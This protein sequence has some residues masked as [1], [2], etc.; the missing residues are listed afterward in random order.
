MANNLDAILFD[1][2]NN[3]IE[4][5]SLEKPKTYQELLSI[6]KNKLKKLPN[7]FNII[8]QTLNG[9]EINI[10]SDQEFKLI[11]DIIFIREIKKSDLDKSIFSLNYNNLSESKQEILDEKFNCSICFKNI[12]NENP[13][14]CYK[15]Q[16]IFH[17]E[18]LDDWDKKNKGQNKNLSCP[19][20]RNELPLEKWEHKL[21]FEDDRKKE[22]YKMDKFSQYDLIININK[23]QEKKINELIL[24]NEKYKKNLEEPFNYIKDILIKVD[25]II[26]IKNPNNIQN[27]NNKTIDLIKNISIKNNNFPFKDI[28]QIIFKKL[29]IIKKNINN[30]NNDFKYNNNDLNEIK[31]L[32]E[33]LK[34]L[35][36]KNDLMNIYEFKNEFNLIYFTKFEGYFNIF[37]KSFILNNK[38]K[39]EI[40]I[41]D[42]KKSTMYKY[43]LNKGDNKIKILIK[44]KLTNLE[45]MFSECTTLK[46]IG[47]LKFLDTKEI[48]SFTRM[49][50][51]CTSLTD[52]TALMNWN[53]SNC[54]DFSYMFSECTSLSE[55]DSLQLWNV[56]NG[57]N[58]S[59]MFNSCIAL[60]NIKPLQY[61]N[62]LNDQ[63]YKAMFK[64]C[65]SL[66]NKEPLKKWKLSN[67]N[68]K[69]LFNDNFNVPSHSFEKK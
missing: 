30:L 67:K 25:E 43:Q 38:N 17:N 16:K 19:N 37:G 59:Y 9:N 58:F 45:N 39:I 31:K 41:N 24:E 1:I 23:T 26:Y 10:K 62:I 51:G 13:L 68:F 34:E 6:L 11:K 5:I 20:C 42:I 63:N 28:S 60:S 65:N 27:N 44:N 66:K 14:F 54:K 48:T 7:Y 4:E 12:K 8:I 36:D 40:F 32:E 56:S 2:S 15:C 64:G 46:D 21:G 33:K 18:C 22:A 52:I 35:N 61:W 55:I 53:V 57:T 3:I 69:L 29:E 49:F 50:N 47:D